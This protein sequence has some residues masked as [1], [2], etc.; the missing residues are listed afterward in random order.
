MSKEEIIS[1]AIAKYVAEKGGYDFYASRVDR[2]AIK[3]SEE[4]YVMLFKK[5]TLEKLA[6]Y[7]MDELGISAEVIN[8]INQ[9]L[10]TGVTNEELNG[11]EFKSDHRK[12]VGLIGST[13]LL[14]GSICPIVSLPV[15]G[16]VNYLHNG[17]GDGLLII[18]IAIASAYFALTSRYVQLR[19]TGLAA[20]AVISTT[21]WMFQIKIGEIKASL[22]RDL[23]DNPFRGLADLAFSS[24]RL[25]WGWVLLIGG[26][27]TL[28]TLS[29]LVKKESTLILPRHAIRPE[30]GNYSSNIPL[31]VGLTVVFG[32][33][34]A[35]ILNVLGIAG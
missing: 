24:V 15:V 28:I 26:S 22:E 4:G 2:R 29:C 17:R 21:L 12:I 23:A 20:L 27:M 32:S 11:F 19:R 31:L 10:S 25:E 8:S 30:S 3:I 6:T 16:S 34:V 33:V 7:Q 9:P 1:A 18:A 13:V 5:K 14:I 35:T